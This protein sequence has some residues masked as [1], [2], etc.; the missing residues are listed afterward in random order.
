LE[1]RRPPAW[2]EIPV[3]ELRRFMSDLVVDS[4][5]R[6]AGRLIGR[7][8]E[9]VRRF[10]AGDIDTPHDRTREAI[11]RLYLQKHGTGVKVAAEVAQPGSSSTPLKLI[12][13]PGAE[14]A[15]AEIRA[16]FEALRRESSELPPTT[17][18]IETWLRRR[19]KEEYAAEQPY[20]RQRQRTPRPP[21]EDQS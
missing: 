19:V 2:R 12:L 14:R 1:S 4:N 9:A 20:P 3:E 17:S 13:P 15:T 7:G 18:A 8:R 5:L 10:V 21:R 11:A 6:E 16:M